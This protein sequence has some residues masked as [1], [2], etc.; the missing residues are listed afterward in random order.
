MTLTQLRYIVAIV[1][2][3]LNITLAAERVH[4]TQPGISRQL[5]QLEDEL[6]FQ[7][8]VRKGKSLESIST[9]GAQVIARARIILSEAANI[10]VLAANFRSENDGELVIV[11]TH[12][13]ARFVLPGAIADIKRRYADV[14]IRLEPHG[15][16]ELMD[17]LGKGAADLA[18]VSTA[19]AAPNAELA[20]PL[21]RWDRQILL[22]RDHP[23]ASLGRVPRI[24]ELARHALVSYESSL[25][26]ESSLRRAFVD[27]GCDLNLAVTARDAD[28]IKT[29]VRSGLGVGVLAEMALSEEDQAEFHVF[30]ARDLLPTCTSWV[31]L[32]RDRVQ[33]NY[34]LDLIIALAP[35]IDRRDLVRVVQGAALADWP[36]PPHWSEL[37]VEEAS[38]RAA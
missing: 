33:R 18:I 16:T 23:L 29:Y 32:Q 27:A 13:Q 20:I 1:D 38:I 26:A 37:G 12:T 10:R 30:S 8:F 3:G 6:G 4:A 24:D 25:N 14:G 36:T 19:S 15:D 34:A 21:F 31:V 9:A 11:S 7:M 22:T 35:H 5:R 28:L 2:A 17:L